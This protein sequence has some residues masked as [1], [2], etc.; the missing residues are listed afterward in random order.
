MAF[1]GGLALEA[2]ARRYDAEAG[3]ACGG[4][5]AGVRRAHAAAGLL[6]RYSAAGHV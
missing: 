3:A 4:Y 2:A 5:F 6:R 1:P